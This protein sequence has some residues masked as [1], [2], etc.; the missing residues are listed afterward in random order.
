M[1]ND[2]MTFIGS[3]GESLS[4][5]EVENRLSRYLD[6]ELS[7]ASRKQFERHIEQCDACSGLVADCEA[8]T[9]AAK[10]LA[11]IP[12]PAGVSRRLRMKLEEEVSCRFTDTKPR[13]YLVK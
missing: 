2:H 13:L 8:I 11:D 6:G 5:A 7:I 12:V 9:A 10:S 4:C 3:A 1:D